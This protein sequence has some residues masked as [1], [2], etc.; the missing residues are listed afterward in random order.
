MQIVFVGVAVR[1]RDD[2]EDKG[3]EYAVS[4]S[5]GT[6]TVQSEHG[7]RPKGKSCEEALEYVLE[8]AKKYSQ[9]RGHK[10]RF[11]PPPVLP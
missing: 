11:M 4:V 8:L 7:F 9:Q 1:E 3:P 6:G 5:D 10:V 2:L